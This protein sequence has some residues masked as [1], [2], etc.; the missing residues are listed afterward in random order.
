M[1]VSRV[2]FISVGTI[3]QEVVGPA[4]NR[5]FLVLWPGQA[6]RVTLSN[7]SPAVLDNGLTLSSGTTGIALDVNAHGGC[8]TGAWYGIAAVAGTVLGIIDVLDG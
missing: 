4:P 8:V 2:S 6:G 3:S 7:D 1:R 5:V